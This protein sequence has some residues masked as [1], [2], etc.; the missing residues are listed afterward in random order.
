MERASAF[1]KLKDI[2]ILILSKIVYNLLVPFESIVII[3]L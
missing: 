2:S 1:K 3:R